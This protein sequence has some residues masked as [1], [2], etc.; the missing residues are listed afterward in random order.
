MILVMRRTL[1]A[2]FL[3][4][5]VGLCAFAVAG[6]AE[7]VQHGHLRVRFN[8]KLSPSVLPRYGARAVAVSI[9][10]RVRTTDGSEPPQLRRI[11]L[12]I[13]RHGHFETS[14]L[15][16]CRLEQIQPSTNEQ[17]L[18]ACRHAK[19]GEGLFFANVAIPGQAPFPSRGRLIAFNGV[20]DGRRVI[21]AHVYGDE[22]VPTSYTLPFFIERAKGTFSTKLSAALPH[23][24]G[25]AGFI[26]G[27]QLNLHRTYRFR[28]KR[29]SYLSAGCPAPKGINLAPF[30]LARATFVFAGRSLSSVLT[31]SCR[32]AG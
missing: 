27:I 2:C 8:G 9:G 12:A 19:V 3:L 11:E 28:G 7:S 18:A 31:R 23:V 24:T 5:L 22:P 10:G 25:K 21:F 15:P 1:F 30:K 6:S 16:T 26:T 14:G 20:E 17:A 32:P 4:V 13:N 29:R